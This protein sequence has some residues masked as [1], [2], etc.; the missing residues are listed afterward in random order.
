MLF[1]FSMIRTK[2][3]LQRREL[4][5]KSQ[6]KYI[7]RITD[8]YKKF[9]TDLIKAIIGPRRAGKSFFA[10]HFLNKKSYGY[11]NFDDEELASLTDYDELIAE[12]DA[13]YNKPK[14]LF[15][16]EMQNL[17][18]WE[19]F[20]NRLQRQGYNIILTGSN[21]KLLS[22]EL[23]THLTGRHFP[24][25]VFPFSFK[26]YLETEERE[27]TQQEIKSKLNDYVVYGGYPEPLVKKINY[28]EYLSV[29]FD[30][31]LFKDVV[32]RFKIRHTQAI[33]SLAR[34]LLG[35]IAREYSY[36]NL[37]KVA[38]FKSVFTVQK[39]LDYLEESFIFFKFERF[40]PKIKDQ[41]ASNKKIYCIDN[42]FVYAEAFKLSPDLGRL[43]ENTVAIELKKMEMKGKAEIYFWKNPEQEEVDFIIKQGLKITQLIQVCY[44]VSNIE[45]KQREIR[46]LLK[47]SKELKCKKLLIITEDYEKEEN[48]EWFGYKG[49]IKYIPLWKWLLEA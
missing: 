42:G 6:E 18:K 44:D 28:K 12:I 21:S 14:F 27:L 33:E 13:L 38:K 1:S 25:I 19:L 10:I 49:K 45:T 40:S 37:A 30:S 9:D 7:E 17:P 29:L 5:K 3:L 11:A 20:V 16:D 32:K 41:I 34:F 39:Y 2:L 8:D 22:K 48:A 46:A 35:N 15:L 36:N 24:I 4:E 43:Y 26:E 31:I 23:S 47:A